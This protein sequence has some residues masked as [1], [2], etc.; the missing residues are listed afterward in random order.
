MYFSVIRV[1]PNDDQK[2]YLLGVGQFKSV[3]GGVTF[4]E[5]LGRSVHADGHALWVD[6][7]DGKHMIIGVDGGVYVTYDQGRAWDHLNT[8]QSGSSIT[9]RF[10]P[11][12]LTT[13]TA[14]YK[15]ME[16]GEAQP[17]PCPVK[18]L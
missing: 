3:D 18:D 5:S 8:L 13:C 4:D 16:R 17:F 2:I 9:L 15:T 11:S 6:P 7:K 12:T 14:V 1:D 10:R